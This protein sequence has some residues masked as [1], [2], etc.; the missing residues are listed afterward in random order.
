MSLILDA[1]R[2]SEAERR[3]A[4]AAGDML[5]TAPRATATPLA[6]VSAW[7]W[8]VL[9][10]VTLALA[11]WLWLGRTA[12]PSATDAAT[13]TTAGVD[14][15]NGLDRADARQDSE[16]T[17][18]MDGTGVAYSPPPPTTTHGRRPHRARSGR[19]APRGRCRSRRRGAWGGHGCGVR[20]AHR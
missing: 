8:P 15:I 16:A 10:V 3:K 2:K 17:A 19:G 6:S 11:G 14:G 1:L 4:Q 18:G 20:R 13:A 9:A 12:D 5:A 7:L